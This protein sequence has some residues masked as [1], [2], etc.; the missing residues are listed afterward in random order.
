MGDLSAF[1]SEPLSEQQRQQL[2][3]LTGSVTTEQA[4]WLSGYFAG[5]EAGIARQGGAAVPSLAPA[6]APVATRTLT[7]L[8]GGETG[9]SAAIARSFAAAATERNL[10]V[11]LVDIASY[12]PRQLKSEEDLALVVATHGDGDPPHP[13][14]D[15]FEFV[16]G[17]KAPK[18]PDLR[19]AVLAL[20]DSS[21][22]YF[23]QAGKRLDARFEE[24]GATRLTARVD[25]DVDYDE[26]A[27]AWSAETLAILAAEAQVS[28]AQ[29]ATPAFAKAAFHVKRNPF[30]ARVVDN[31]SIV[32]R[33]STKDVRHIEF[34]IT[35]S[36]LD[37]QPGDGLGIAPRNS[38]E[39]VADLLEAAG[40]SGEAP[41]TIKGEQVTL[42]GALESHFEIGTTV[43]RFLDHWA[44]LT[45]SQELHGLR[46]DDRKADRLEWLRGHHV[47]DVVRKY[48][49]GGLDAGTFVAG[50]RPLQPR[51]Y[52][53]AS[54]LAA[55]PDE[56]HITLSPLRYDL[57]GQER[58]GTASGHLADRLAVGD[59]LPVYIQPN[60]QFRLPADDVPI[61]MVG[62]GTGVA[63]FR[64]FLQE[65]EARGA[66]GR[67]WLFFGERNFR[68]NFFYQVEWQQWLKDDLLTRMDVA[69][70]RDGPDKV[71]VQQRLV[72]HASD[73]FGWL[74]QG[75]HFY[76]CGDAE[77]MA[78]DVHEALITVAATA[79]RMGREAAETYVREL[80]RS[81]RYHRDVY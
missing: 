70:S 57:H 28:K 26:P 34:D 53:L 32:G 4:R 76:V 67:N 40:L 50:L 47:V 79:G 49:L 12:K 77:A 13:A 80:Q 7:V 75:A 42:A 48:P 30:Q 72:E 11:N 10:T 39:R 74:E 27:A 24:L 17:P 22:E 51:V 23:C 69:F 1:A 33:Q 38:S 29:T 19:F 37:F 15:F 68:S 59:T 18:L 6:P 55:M 44:T 61:I 5:L 35:D 71:Y 60:D 43:P 62:P 3:V 66:P 73:L 64:A 21:Y 14:M 16:E 58:H 2:Q 41:L 25:C 52:S 54:S 81:H 63:P 45:Q 31:L 36:G 78:P 9:N 56:A 65:R 8:H 20:G 46:Q